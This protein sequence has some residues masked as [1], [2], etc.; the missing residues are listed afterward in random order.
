MSTK[1]GEHAG[2]AIDCQRYVVIGGGNKENRGLNT[3]KMF[4]HQTK[5]WIDIPLKI[6][7]HIVVWVVRHVL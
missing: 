1:R 5:Q 2:V 4:N 6:S 3:L 7:C